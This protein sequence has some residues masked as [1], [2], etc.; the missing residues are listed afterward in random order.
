MGPTWD[1]DLSFGNYT[2]DY[3]YDSWFTCEG[4][5]LGTTWTSYLYQDPEFNKKYKD[6]WNEVKK[7]L[8]ETALSAVE[9]GKNSIYASQK[10]N[11]KKWNK[12]LGNKTTLQPE[13]MRGY[14]T[15]DEHIAYLISFINNRYEWLDRAINELP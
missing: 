12:L 11:F 13:H 6:R 15:F 1:F 7:E 3:S 14:K 10:Y 9:G 5:T 8:K 4:E 2:K